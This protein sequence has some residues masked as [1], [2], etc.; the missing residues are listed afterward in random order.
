MTDISYTWRVLAVVDDIMEVEYL[1]I[2][3]GAANFRLQ[4]PYEDQT[5]EDVVMQFAP[6]DE[7]WMSLIKPK[8]T[9][10]A[11]Q[12]GSGIARKRSVPTLQTVVL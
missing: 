1:A 9:V 7:Y 10:S 5:V 4:V 12:T 2:G 3:Y 6:D 11:G 8:L